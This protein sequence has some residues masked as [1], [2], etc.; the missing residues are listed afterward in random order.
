M[1]R[2]NI[3]IK[4]ILDMP[5]SKRNKIA[6][7]YIEN[8]KIIETITYN[9]ILNDIDIYSKYFKSLNLVDRVC[10]L[11][12]QAGVDFLSILFG[13]I[14]ANLKPIIRTI[15][16]SVSKDKVINQIEELKNEMPFI[17]LIIT[18]CEFEDFNII[19]N[20][21]K[22][23]F[24][25]LK[26]KDVNLNF[27]NI[28]KDIDGDI[29]L[30]TSGSTKVSKGV[31]ISI[32]ELE[33]NVKFC[34]S[35]WDINENDICMNW[36][37]H[38]HI[39]GL[40]TGFLLPVYTGSSSYIMSP[41][42]FSLKFDTFF[43]GLSK[44]NITNTHTPAS[45]LF[46]EKGIEYVIKNQPSNFDLSKLKTVS[47]GG[48]AINYKLLESFLENLSKYRFNSN[49]FSPNYGMSE[50]SGLL[51]AIKINESVKTIVVDEYDLKFNN[52]VNIT[53]K[54]N[55]CTLVSVGKVSCDNVIMFEPFTYNRLPNKT[56]GEIVIS[57]PSLS[58][59]YIN[60]NDN[61]NFVK[62]NNDI[63][64]RTGDLGFV[65][66]NNYLFVTGRLK[67]IIKIKGKN[68]S[69]YEIENCLLNSEFKEF[70][71][72]VVV[73]SKKD[74]I[75]S[76]EEIGIFIETSAISENDDIIKK[77]MLNLI[78]EKLQIKV[79]YTNVLFLR[80]NRIP[81]F[82]NGKISR[83][84]CNELFQKIMEDENEKS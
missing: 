75:D 6:F 81:R 54:F 11:Y 33:E 46:L 26:N 16:Q 55:S 77:K 1:E 36:M 41:K 74:K 24:I 65:D 67:E 44:F 61:A 31:Q 71:N 7:S 82:S 62:Y 10:I 40:V 84:K 19:C 28:S 9:K 78:D 48:E 73:F 42:E 52:T 58:N 66:E 68:I 13:C 51:C 63:Y 27:N 70:I 12:L 25:D 2:E 83:K 39:Y 60:K 29:I 80:K 14:E 8:N 3:F 30:L 56:I 72:N 45:N 35:L 34:Q 76:S 32:K 57:V 20:K 37:P 50:I 5:I 47:L 22:I 64:Y 21:C 79:D 53:N 49:A 4:K 23:N 15:G 17:N 59:G 69:P 38:S 43:E 18:N